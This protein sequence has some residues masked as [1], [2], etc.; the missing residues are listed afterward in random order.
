MIPTWRQ[1]VISTTNFCISHESSPNHL[2]QKFQKSFPKKI[3]SKVTRRQSF[4]RNLFPDAWNTVWRT[5]SSLY[6]TKIFRSISFSWCANW[7]TS[8]FEVQIRISELERS[9]RRLIRKPLPCNHSNSCGRT[10]Q[11]Y[12]CFSLSSARNQ[13]DC[14]S[15]ALISSKIFDKAMIK[16][17][18]L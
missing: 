8:K 18:R 14:K 7:A 16:W 4:N 11:A 17:N 12:S 10:R 6:E 15:K 5:N 1:R 13:D 2:M 3:K 9:A